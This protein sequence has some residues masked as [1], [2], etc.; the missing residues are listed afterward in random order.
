MKCYICRREEAVVRIEGKNYCKD[1][2]LKLYEKRVEKVIKKW[3]LIENGDRVMVALSGGKDSASMLYFLNKY[4]KA[5][6]FEL[7][8]MFIH[9]WT[10]EYS[11]LA[12]EKSKELTKMLGIKLHIVD[13]KKG[14]GKTLIEI[15]RSNRRRAI[16]SICGIVKRYYMNKHPRERGFNKIATGHNMDD[17]LE[18]FIKNF[19][20]RNFEW[21]D[22]LKPIV[23]STHPKLLTKIRPLYECSNVENY[24]YAKFNLLPFIESKCPFSKISKWK[25]I[26]EC[27]DT[28]IPGSKRQFTRTIE[29]L[30]FSVKEPEYKQCK[31]CGELTTSKNG[32]CSFCKLIHEN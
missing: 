8:A 16:C 28:N 17:I 12:L 7:E 22:K 13:I 9:L 2:F 25:N 20:D 21:N 15:V 29:E 27:F 3:K 14:T 32:I 5:V 31:I 26:V 6:D 18:F 4:K 1:C 19:I 11:D 24:Y 10:P 30:N 23:P